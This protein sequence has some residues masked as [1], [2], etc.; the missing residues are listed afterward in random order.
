MM[1][2][3]EPAWIEPMVTTPNWEGSFSRLTTLC[4]STT[5][6]AASS[7]GSMV[8]AGMEPWPPRPLNWIWMLSALEVR[9]PGL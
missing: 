3:A 1:L 2:P 8:T 7:T 6:R 4:R 5:K 9:T